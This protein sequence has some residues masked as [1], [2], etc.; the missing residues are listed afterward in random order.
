MANDWSDLTKRVA[1]GIAEVR[2]TTGAELVAEGQ[3][4]PLAGRIAERA[5]ELRRRRRE[6]T[7][8]F[9]LILPFGEAEVR[10]ELDPQD[11]AALTREMV[12]FWNEQGEAASRPPQPMQD[13]TKEDEA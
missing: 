2:K 6:D 8:R 12:R 13:D 4:V 7:H 5:I 3:P 1:R 9:V 10:V 11:Y